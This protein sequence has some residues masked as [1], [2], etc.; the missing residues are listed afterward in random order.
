V[1]RATCVNGARGGTAQSR[2]ANWFKKETLGVH[3]GNTTENEVPNGTLSE[4][5]QGPDRKVGAAVSA[6]QK[7]SKRQ[8]KR[9]PK[10]SA[11]C[12]TLRRRGGGRMKKEKTAGRR[13]QKSNTGLESRLKRSTHRAECIT[14]PKKKYTAAVSKRGS[15]ENLDT[16]QTRAG[17]FYN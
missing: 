17:W 15:G 4:K 5:S 14:V 11:A 16:N 1:P 9:S 7:T 13:G 10:E 8:E 2:P 6:Q 12:R 3:G